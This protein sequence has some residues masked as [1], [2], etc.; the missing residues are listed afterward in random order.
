MDAF[1]LVTGESKDI[2]EHYRHHYPYHNI[3]FTSTGHALGGGLAQCLLYADPV[4]IK[5]AYT[6]NPSLVTG[7][8][9]Q[10]AATRYQ[11]YCDCP[12]S[13]PMPRIVRIYS[14][15][16]LLERVRR[17]LGNFLPPGPH[18]QEVRFGFSKPWNSIAQHAM[19]PLASGILHLAGWLPLHTDRRRRRPQQPSTGVW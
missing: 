7:F 13:P 11:A 2:F 4:R 18:V 3:A 10:P 19:M 14:H 16:T 15:G 8:R 12:S 1:D 5:R 9:G 17:I 6:F